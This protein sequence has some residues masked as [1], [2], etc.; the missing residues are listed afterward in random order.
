MQIAHLIYTLLQLIIYKHEKYKEKLQQL[1]DIIYDQQLLINNEEYID[2]Q[3]L[4]L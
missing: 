4:F 2:D 3:F 1:L